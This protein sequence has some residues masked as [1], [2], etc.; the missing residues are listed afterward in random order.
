MV[1]GYPALT[2]KEK[3]TLRMLLAGHDAK[4]IARQLGL[5]VHTINERL[6]EARRKL[7]ASSSREAARLLRDAEGAAPQLVGDDELGD[8]PIVQPGADPIVSI[9]E[10]PRRG[11][12]V[13]IIGAIAMFALALALYAVSATPEAPAVAAP[14]ATVP[15]ETAP[16]QSA[17]QWLEQGDAG[18]WARSYAATAASFRKLNTLAVWEDV[19]KK[20]RVPLGALV[21]RTLISDE[22]I[23]TP[24]AG[25]HLV[26]FRSRFAN[27][28]EAVETLTVVKED[29][30]WRVMGIYLE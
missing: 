22:E 21:S 25:S 7:S 1:Q 2:E 29:G 10:P 5:S 4:S 30:G 6:R 3:Q 8:A 20:V 14:E 24:P 18:D 17:R 13:W 19:S 28:A 11:F 23:P 26:K 16:V 15:S 27:K 12:A 9:A